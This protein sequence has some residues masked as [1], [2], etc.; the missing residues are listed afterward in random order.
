MYFKS[1]FKK[2]MTRVT[3]M[4]IPHSRAKYFRTSIPMVSL[5][6]LLGLSIIGAVSLV[7]MTIKT[8]DYYA[9]KSRLSYFSKEFNGLRSTIVSLRET[10]EELS[11]LL[12]FNSKKGILKSTQIPD[13]GSLDI[14]LLKKQVNETIEAVSDIKNYIAQQKDIYAS[15]PEGWPVRGTVTSDFGLREHPITHERAH[16]AGVDIRAPVGTEVK[17]TA[18]GIVSFASWMSG[19]GYIVVLE[20]GHGFSTAYAHNKTNL[21]TVG[22]RV[23]KGEAIALSGSTGASTGPHVHYEVWKN[24][25]QV[26]PSNYLKEG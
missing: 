19:S 12:S 7:S 16:H 14:E 18:S 1:L 6:V 26:D 3:I 11:K 8:M 17:A 4:V 13:S 2:S 21:V 10:N 5:L 22:Q 23:K 9:M 20:H 25:K 24:R 15:T